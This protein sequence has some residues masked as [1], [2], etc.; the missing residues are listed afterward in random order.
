MSLGI[1]KLIKSHCVALAGPK[2]TEICLLSTE[3]EGVHH[4]SWLTGNLTM[5][6]SLL[7]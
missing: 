3:T 2:H 4:Y 7:N 1:F 5:R 6:L